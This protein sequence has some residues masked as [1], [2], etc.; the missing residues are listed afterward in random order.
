VG[1][2]VHMP[3]LI[4]AIAAWLWRDIPAP[5]IACRQGEAQTRYRDRRP[6]AE[7]LLLGLRTQPAPTSNRPGHEI[8]MRGRREG[9]E[10]GVELVEEDLRVRIVARHH[11]DDHHPVSMTLGDL[12]ADV[13]PAAT[14]REDVR[15]A[16]SLF[17]VIRFPRVVGLRDLVIE[18]D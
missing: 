2:L 13:R 10:E 8:R 6:V 3:A 18:S 17:Q 5:A 14:A 7:S 15:A 9:F 12:V 11:R 16:A 4:S 1:R